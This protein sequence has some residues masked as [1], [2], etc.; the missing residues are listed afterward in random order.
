MADTCFSCKFW[1]GRKTKTPEDGRS[2][3][4]RHSPMIFKATQKQT[5]QFIRLWPE[6]WGYDW[7]GDYFLDIDFAQRKA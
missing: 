3:C 7:C 1:E 4:R 6:V 2:F 5:P